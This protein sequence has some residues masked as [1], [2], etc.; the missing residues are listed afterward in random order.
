MKALFFYT[1]RWKAQ[2][3]NRFRLCGIIAAGHDRLGVYFPE[4]PMEQEEWESWTVRVLDSHGHLSPVKWLSELA[5]SGNGITEEYDEV[6]RIRAASLDD[7]LRE[8]YQLTVSEFNTEMDLYGEPVAETSQSHYDPLEE[9]RPVPSTPLDEETGFEP[10]F[11]GTTQMFH[12]WR[13]VGQGSFDVLAGE[14]V[15]RP[16]PDLGLLYYEPRKF[17]NFV[18]R[19]E[20][21]LHQVDADSGVFVRF[22]DPSLPVPDRTNPT[23]LHPYQNPAWVPVHTGIE[24]QISS[25]VAHPQDSEQ[26]RA[27]VIYGAP[28][29]TGEG[30]GASEPILPPMM[31]EWNELEVQVQDNAYVVRLNGNVTTQL[32]N[33][34]PYRGRSPRIDPFSGYIGLQCYKGFVTFRRIRV[35]SLP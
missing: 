11:D 18:L 27:G 19:L 31:R 1:S 5:E 23:L 3:T 16:G 6:R 15:T 17:D 33:T 13:T 26:H 10:L 2:S 4:D 12:Q 34:D 14:I 25:E 20:F 28:L 21:V 35:K 9:L 7:A 8:A 29:V 24:V 32:T 30:Q 22:R